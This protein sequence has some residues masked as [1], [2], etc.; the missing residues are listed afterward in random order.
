L[1][2]QLYTRYGRQEWEPACV[3]E[4]DVAFLKK[5]LGWF[6]ALALT[7]NRRAAATEDGT[8]TDTAADALPAAP[9]KA[10]KNLL[11]DAWRTFV[12]VILSLLALLGLGSA[13]LIGAAVFMYLTVSGKLRS[14]MQPVPQRSAVYAETFAIWMLTFT[15]ISFAAAFLVRRLEHSQLL[16]SSVGS[17]LSLVAV[18]WPLLRGVS[19][20]QIL[21]DL[22]VLTERR[23]LREILW[24]L[25]CY[26]SNIPVILLGLLIMLVLLALYNAFVTGAGME[27]A[28]PPAHPII[29]WVREANWLSRL[30]ICLLACVIAPIVEE[31]V[32]RGVLYRHLRDS[33][34][35]WRTSAS[36]FFSTLLNSLIFAVIHPQGLLAAPALTGVAVGL[37]LA[38]EWRGSL[39]APMTM[40]A[41]NNGLMMLLL[42]SL[43]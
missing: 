27:Q 14:A 20:R 1:L 25:V 32:F 35:A 37:S 9:S 19:W 7:P 6:G 23:V 13:G 28:Q 17:M 43:L 16:V 11:A 38:R 15:A 36:V 41:A 2:R 42:F 29:N 12:T 4:N 18:A 34:A 30:H 26:V 3:D 22:G 24:G 31:T 8:D 33:T 10:R 5:E 40:H 21:E 39:L